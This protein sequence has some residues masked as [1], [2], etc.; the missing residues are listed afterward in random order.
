MK[1]LIVL[2][3]V[4]AQTLGL[5][6]IYRGVMNGFGSAVDAGADSKGFRT[7]AG[8]GTLAL[9]RVRLEE[10][11]LPLVD[12]SL[13]AATVAAD[14]S[15]NAG[16]SVGASASF[17]NSLGLGAGYAKSGTTARVLIPLSAVLPL[18]TC[19][20]PTTSFVFYAAPTWNFEHISNTPVHRWGAS[21]SSFSL[22]A[23]VELYNGIGFQVGGGGPFSHSSQE[24]YHRN[25]FSVGMHFSPHSI[26]QSTPI[27]T[28]G[29]HFGL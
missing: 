5:P 28:Y 22:G 3:G 17:L 6:I 12:L 13:T 11:Q 10:G 7:V 1:V 14:D 20:R 4:T 29:C 24:V 18:A 25:V 23:L 16:W 19:L 27:G 8:T 15:S 9:G 26:A 2:P 21:W